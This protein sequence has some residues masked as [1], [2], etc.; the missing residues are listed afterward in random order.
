MNEPNETLDDQERLLLDV[1]SGEL[2]GG[3]DWEDALEL[4]RR[5]L[6]R[7][8]EHKP[9]ADLEAIYYVVTTAAGAE[10]ADELADREA[11]LRGDD[12]DA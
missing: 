9:A 8:V 3:W 7:I 10:L 6:V 12:H 4:E 11:G 1:A 5:G 2:R